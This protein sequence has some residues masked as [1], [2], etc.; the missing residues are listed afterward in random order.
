VDAEA[1]EETEADGAWD[2]ADHE[3]AAAAEAEDLDV[4]VDSVEEIEAAEDTEVEG[5]EGI[6]T[7][8]VD[9]EDTK[10]RAATETVEGTATNMATV[11][12]TIPGPCPAV[13][14]VA[15]RSNCSIAFGS[16][17][18]WRTDERMNAV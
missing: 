11:A 5:L 18:E 15:H 6:G 2:S 12:T 9:T 8:T 17:K 7:T 16:I 3:V 4:A 13:T 1:E 14:A 10:I